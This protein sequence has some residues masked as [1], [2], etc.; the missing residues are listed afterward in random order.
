MAAWQVRQC[1]HLEFDECKY[2]CHSL[3]KCQDEQES[4]S[5]IYLYRE[6]LMDLN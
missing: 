1:E 4:P 5:N 3:H 2:S 6:R